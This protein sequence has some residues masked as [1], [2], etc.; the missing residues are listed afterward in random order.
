MKFL[1][2]VASSFHPRGV[3]EN[4]TLT[5]NPLG[6][7]AH[8]QN[9]VSQDDI[10]N[11]INFNL[12]YENLY[13]TNHEVDFLI[14]S[15]NDPSGDFEYG[16]QFLKKIHNKQLANGKVMT[17]IRDNVGRQFGGFNEA[18]EK[19]RD[20][21]DYFIFQ[22]DD[23]ICFMPDYLETAL[24]IWHKTENCGF[25][26]FIGATKVKKSHRRA[27]G[28][29]KNEIVSCHG[30]HGMSSNEVLNSVFKKHGSLPFN[31]K[32]NIFVDHLRDGEIMFTYSILRLGYS[33]GKLPKITLLIAPAYDLMR[34]LEI[35]KNPK[36]FDLIKYYFGEFV[37]KPLY[38]F[39]K[40]AGLLKIIKRWR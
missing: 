33:F 39:V 7:F 16:Y 12:S 25:V 6:F 19:F 17:L 14:V 27:L 11:L 2:I 8:S 29:K 28:I 13:K 23:M 21:Y 5:G 1:K 3:R 15:S 9:F 20:Q 24:D 40:E 18:F 37:K 30:A 34:G 31:S 10:I 4:T 36:I 35:K 22:E 32:N 38:P 26:P